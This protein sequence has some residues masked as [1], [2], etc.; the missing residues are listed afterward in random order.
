M[1]NHTPI[2]FVVSIGVH[3]KTVSRALKRNAAPKRVLRPSRATVRFETSVGEQL[4]T[5]WGE[6]VVEIAGQPSKAERSAAA[7]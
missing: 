4:Q 6:V 3:P 7:A 1:L 2:F 5:D